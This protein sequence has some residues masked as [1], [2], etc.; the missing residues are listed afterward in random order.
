MEFWWILGF[1]LVHFL[2]WGGAF[3]FFAYGSYQA[4]KAK[5][6]ANTMGTVKAIAVEQR[7]FGRKKPKF[8]VDIEVE[9]RIAGEIY[10]CDTFHLNQV[11]YYKSVVEAKAAAADYRVGKVIAIFTN[12][13]IPEQST[14]FNH[15]A[16]V[17]HPF[18][19]IVLV[20]VMAC[21]VAIM[22]WAFSF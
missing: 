12:P 11:I 7:A 8:E 4:Y 10:I 2:G 6:W 5:S 17:A 16:V 3:A 9:Y 18:L 19:M 20:G 1:G 14:I 21:S 15:L 22:V 13:D